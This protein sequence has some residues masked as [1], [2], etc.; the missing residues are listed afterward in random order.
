MRGRGAPLPL[1]KVTAGPSDPLAGRVRREDGE[2]GRLKM[3]TARAPAT[4]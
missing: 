4:V 3:P 1:L 2:G